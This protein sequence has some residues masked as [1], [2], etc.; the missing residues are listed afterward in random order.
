V[1]RLLFVAVL[2]VMGA[3]LSG[4][5]SYEGLIP[6]GGVH[7]CQ[8]CHGSGYSL[9]PFGEDFSGEG[10]RWTY[11]LSQADSDGGGAS[12]GAELLDPDGEWEQG[13]PDPGDPADVTN[14]GNPGDDQSGVESTTWGRI[15]TFEP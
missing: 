10:N 6:N 11:A 9:N 13:E 7:S 3:L 2:L 4:Y 14:P 1:K 5:G 12:N 15:K 8:T